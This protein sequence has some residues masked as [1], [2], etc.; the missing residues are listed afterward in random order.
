MMTRARIEII[1]VL[2]AT[3]C[4]ISALAA[5]EAAHATDLTSDLLQAAPEDLQWFRDAKFGLFIHWGPVSQAGTEISF[6]RGNPIP[7]DQYDSLYKT[8]NPTKFDAKRWVAIA[9][10]AGMKYLV[11]TTKHHD[12]FCEFDSKLTDYKITN[13]P[14]RRDIVAELSRACHKAGLKLGFYYSQPDWNNPDFRKNRERYIEYLHGQLRELCTNYGKVDVVWFDGL[15]CTAR[16]MDSPNLIRMIRRLQPHVLINNR[17]ALRADFDTPEQT[18]GKF[19]ANRPWESCI[20]IG[21]Q[22][23]YKPNEP[24]KSTDEC[25]RTLVRCA[26]GDGNLL[27]NVGP[28]PTGE[29]DPLHVQRLAEIGGWLKKYGRSVYGTRGGPFISL[30]WGV[31][32]HRGNRV[33]LHILDWPSDTISLPAIPLRIV[34]SYALTG[35]KPVVKQANDAVEITLPKCDRAQTDTIIVLQLD[36]LAASI[37]PP[38]PFSGSLATGKQATASNV[39]LEG[40]SYGPDKA[41]DDDTSTRWATDYGVQSAWLEVDLATTVTFSSAF[42]SEAYDRV[43]EFELQCKTGDDWRTFARGTTI[44]EGLKLSFDPV[45]ARFVRVNVTKSTDG[46]TI[47]E[48]RVK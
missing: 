40:S 11:F 17:A 47:W 24:I 41:V 43:Q 9:K 2:L 31:S 27:L 44:G 5:Q 19:Q 29:I 23:S 26:G 6:S 33:Y 34:K 46:P 30:P 36:G 8:F 42:L 35:G 25:I 21:T 13:S 45:T 15:D 39:Y 37:M 3:L 7:V 38:E 48:F 28:M 22:W 18:I 14:F 20:T 1:A 12:G 32:T 4:I 16:E 10:S